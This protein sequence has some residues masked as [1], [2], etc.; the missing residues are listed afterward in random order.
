[1]IARLAE[2]PGWVLPLYFL[3]IAGGIGWYVRVR[4]RARREYRRML[5]RERQQ[6]G[7]AHAWRLFWFAPRQRRLPAPDRSR[8][9]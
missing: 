9:E 8:S 3:L 2:L 1:M 5:Q 4:L 7:Y 6:A